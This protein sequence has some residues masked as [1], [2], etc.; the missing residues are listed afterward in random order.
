[1]WGSRCQS[2]CYIQHVLNMEKSSQPLS[3]AQHDFVEDMGQLMASWGLPRNTGRLYAF[4]ILRSAPV[5][6]DEMAAEL[7]IAKSG[8][9]L[10]AGPTVLSSA[11]VAA[12]SSGKKVGSARSAASRAGGSAT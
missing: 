4:L 3:S 12:S 2:R 8:A 5:S 11:C 1:M 10:G 6:L 9:S 7:G